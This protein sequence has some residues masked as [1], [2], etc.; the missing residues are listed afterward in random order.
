MVLTHKRVE[1]QKKIKIE[2]LPDD[3]RFKHLP[4][5]E[6]VKLNR[7]RREDSLKVQEYAERLK[8][9]R[10]ATKEPLDIGDENVPFDPNENEI[11][12]LEEKMDGIRGPGSR[13]KKEEV[14]KQI[15]ALKNA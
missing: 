4:K 14:Q 15:D 1:E 5:E 12:K 3:P 2:P 13:A 6:A 8:E 11:A 7:Q 10:K 9:E